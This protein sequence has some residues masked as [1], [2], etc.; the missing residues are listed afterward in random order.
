M[1]ERYATP[2]RTDGIGK[3]NILFTAEH[4]KEAQEVL[5]IA[6]V[7]EHF[8][9]EG[10]LTL[11]AK[12]QQEEYLNRLHAVLIRCANQFG[13]DRTPLD[14][15]RDRIIAEDFA[16]GF[17]WKKPIASP[18]RKLK[19]QAFIQAGVKTFIELVFF[20]S[21]LAEQRRVK[22]SSISLGSGPAEFVLGRIEWIDNQTVKVLQENNRDFWTCSVEGHLEFHFPR[23]EN[24]NPQGIFDLGYMYYIGRYVLPDQKRALEL[25]QLSA[26]AGYKHAQRFVARKVPLKK[27]LPK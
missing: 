5:G 17:F 7:T 19:V 26:A 12:Q 9:T 4:S 8:P 10:F 16:S 11:T 1:F 25:I 3:V 22:F 27:P 13:W 21:K 2:C 14:A 23:A 6:D 20:D 15:T 24:G 18:D